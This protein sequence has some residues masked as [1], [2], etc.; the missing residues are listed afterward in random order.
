[1][2]A[3]ARIG[4]LCLIAMLA[5]CSTATHDAPGQA[6]TPVGPV[7]TAPASARQY[8]VDPQASRIRFIVRRGG[9]LARLGH[10]HVILARQID[11]RIHVADDP[12]RSVLGLTLPVDGFEVDPADERAA[13]GEGF[14]PVPESAVKGTRINMLG[15][16]VLD[17]ARFPEVRVDTVRVQPRGGVLDITV[18]IHLHG[19]ARDVTVP[20]DVVR[21]G[22]MLRARA[23][24]PIRQ[25]DFGMTPLSVLGGALQVEDG[26]EVRMVLVARE[27]A[28]QASGPQACGGRALTPCDNPSL[29]GGAAGA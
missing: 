3:R 15:A 16:R 21:D 10:N 12:A 7:M 20:V 11:G 9:T 18:R 6:R 14:G 19:A 22:A 23:G 4:A 17:A 8:V 2:N 27:V 26:V 5:A 25:S 28:R 1:M 13:L 24:F 29:F